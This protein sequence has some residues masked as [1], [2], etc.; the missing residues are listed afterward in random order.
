MEAWLFL[1]VQET[2]AGFVTLDPVKVQV[3]IYEIFQVL[4]LLIKM[5]FHS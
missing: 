5:S 1:I 2:T 3:L 4:N